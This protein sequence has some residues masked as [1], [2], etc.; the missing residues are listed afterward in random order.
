MKKKPPY[1]IYSKLSVIRSVGAASDD[2]PV[3]AVVLL[4][5]ADVTLL[6]VLVIVDPSNMMELIGSSS[7]VL[8][9]SFVVPVTSS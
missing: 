9:S 7:V 4:I 1:I 2:V 6:V 3:R 8:V 5:A